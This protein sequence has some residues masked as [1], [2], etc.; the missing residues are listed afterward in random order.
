MM[1]DFV[2]NPKVRHF[3]GRIGLCF[4]EDVSVVVYSHH[5]GEFF[6]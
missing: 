3:L 1:D 4:T 5:F 2:L 6:D